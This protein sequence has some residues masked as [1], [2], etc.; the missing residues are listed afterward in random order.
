MDL[1]HAIHDI[2]Q[3]PDVKPLSDI[4]IEL[5]RLVGRLD[6]DLARLRQRVDALERQRAPL[7]VI[8]K[9]AQS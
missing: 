8:G 3:A 6:D 5:L 9:A 1:D 4:V 2:Q 7:H